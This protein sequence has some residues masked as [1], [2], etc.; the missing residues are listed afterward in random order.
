M[1][2]VALGL[3][4]ATLTLGHG[5]RAH[6][7][8]RGLD[9]TVERGEILTIVGPSGS[10]K[11]SLLSVLAGLTP[12][13]RGTVH[14]APGADGVAHPPA[15]VFQQPLLLPWR[16][17]ADNVALGLSYRRHRHLRARPGLRRAAGRRADAQALLDRLGV[18][19]LAARY[20]SEL[21]G[22]QAQ[23]VAIARAV[24]TRPSVLLLDEPFGALDA[25]TRRESQDWLRLLRDTEGVTVVL[26][27]HDLD[28]ALLLGDRVGVLTG[29]TDGLH[30]TAAGPSDRSPD[31]SSRR[32]QDLLSHLGV[33]DL[34]TIDA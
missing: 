17:V 9:L 15:I 11:S 33:A 16:T 29:P 2:T 26:V 14:L 28:E 3:T 30:L 13:D 7:V 6:V 34:A 24:V 22:G 31:V 8:F 4:D 18:G 12:L 5:D 20:P 1:G 25:K 19:D 21:S 10:G 23:R 32:R 27:T